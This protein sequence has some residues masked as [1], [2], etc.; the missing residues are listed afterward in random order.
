MNKSSRSI[1]LKRFLNNIGQS[2]LYINTIAVALSNLPEQDFK[3]DDNLS[4]YWRPKDSKDKMDDLVINSRRYALSGALIFVQ[5][6]LISYINSLIKILRLPSPNKAVEKIETIFKYV[7]KKQEIPKYWRPM[8]VLLVFWRNKIVHN[9][10]STYPAQDKKILIDSFEEIKMNHASI[11]IKVTL[12]NFDKNKITL[13]DFTTFISIA[14]NSVKLFDQV[15]CYKCLDQEM[16]MEFIKIDESEYKDNLLILNKILSNQSEVKKDKRFSNFM[17]KKYGIFDC[18]SLKKD[19]N[20]LYSC[21][22]RELE[23]IM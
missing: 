19:F 18:A 16:F 7:E 2:V 3:K 22:K 11:D 10:S 21:V 14:I 13:K 12:E 4:I 9:S 6:S 20:S 8:L 5:D 23:K 1:L 15:L 17:L